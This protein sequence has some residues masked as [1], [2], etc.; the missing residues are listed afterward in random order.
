MDTKIRLVDLGM[1][2]KLQDHYEFENPSQVQLYTRNR[3]ITHKAPNFESSTI[4]Q[5]LIQWTADRISEIDKPIVKYENFISLFN[6]VS[7]IRG[8]YDDPSHDFVIYLGQ[9]NGNYKVF[10]R[11]AENNIK[12]KRFYHSF[13]WTVGDKL[14]K[15]LNM[16]KYI[17][18][19]YVVYIRHDSRLKGI[20]ELFE[21]K[22]VSYHVEEFDYFDLRHFFKSNFYDKYVENDAKEI[23]DLVNNLYWFNGGALVI[24]YDL[25]DELA[26]H[27]EYQKQQQAQEG[28]KNKKKQNIKEM[29]VR[30]HTPDKEKELLIMGIPNRG[31]SIP[32]LKEFREAVLFL[33]RSLRYIAMDIHNKYENPLVQLF[34]SNNVMMK[35]G[36]VYLFYVGNNL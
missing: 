20:N 11:L 18:R 27:Q 28:N 9:K 31:I 29:K 30:Q 32:F 17:N 21:S 4:V 26:Y 34:I 2:D 13:D 1:I 22:A 3:F 33:P 6:V 16:T 7:R 8:S 12:F 25:G 23:G 24:G 10:R 19:D 5:D 15:R 14:L 35:P 36:Q